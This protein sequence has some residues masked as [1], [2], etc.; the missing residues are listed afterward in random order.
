MIKFLVFRFK[1]KSKE[2]KQIKKLAET[3]IKSRKSSAMFGGLFLSQDQGFKY[4]KL[5]GMYFFVIRLDNEPVLKKAMGIL[6]VTEK[7]AGI[8]IIIVDNQEQKKL[9]LE[10]LGFLPKAD[11]KNQKL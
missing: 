1:A 7:D 9:I 5:E 4:G 10:G 6:S 3:F 11:V 8:E 2:D